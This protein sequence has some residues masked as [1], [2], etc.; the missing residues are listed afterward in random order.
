MIAARQRAGILLAFIIF[1][2]PPSA[3]GVS[4]DALLRDHLWREFRSLPKG[5]RPAVGV[6]FSAGS[7]RAAAHLGVI[8]VL[9]DRGFPVDAVAGTSMGAIVG[10]FYAGGSTVR[11]MLGLSHA[12]KF[13][14]GSN[15]SAA[16]LLSLVLFDSLLS[17]EK[18]E[19]FLRKNLKP[20][21][22]DE[23]K[24]PFA[25]VAMDLFSGEAIVFR[26]GELGPAVRA[27]MSLPGFFTPVEYRHRYL[28]DGGVVSYI[29]IDAARLIGAEWV[30][31][32]ITEPDY[33]RSKPANVLQNL[34]RVIDIRGSILAREQRKKANFLIEPP[35]GDIGMYD[36]ERIQEAIN[37][38]VITANKHADAAMENL[39]L[40]S[41][42]RMSKHWR[43]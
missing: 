41:L 38:G 27:S 3:A 17:S 43:P 2:L 34:E 26:E 39:L 42:P 16:R 33:S 15:Y 4:P 23:M 18:T 14:S 11:E 5:Q 28:V 12:L 40:Y 32:S 9:E 13:S 20:K 1:S 6:V 30:V 24:I 21:R 31:A 35:V 25:C 22:F 37:K 7:M 10:S 29:P 19:A 36:S 8:S